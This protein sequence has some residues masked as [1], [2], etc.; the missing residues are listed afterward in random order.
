MVERPGTARLVLAE[1]A[2]G[3]EIVQPEGMQIGESIAVPPAVMGRWITL[4]SGPDQ[5]I[6]IRDEPGTI[7]RS[8]CRMIF[9]G[10]AYL[11]QGRLHPEGYFLNGDHLTDCT[12]RPLKDGDL[13][14]MGEH[15]TFRFS[16]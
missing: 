16:L 6:V 3:A 10:G 4:G 14:R 1:L 7:R 5:D 2:P 12:G 15:A 13:L 8:H 11:I 9:R